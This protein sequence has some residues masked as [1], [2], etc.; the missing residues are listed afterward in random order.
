VPSHQQ[1]F[2]HMPP[3]APRYCRNRVLGQIAAYSA[4]AVALQGYVVSHLLLAQTITFYALACP[5]VFVLTSAEPATRARLP[6][7]LAL[8]LAAGVEGYAVFHGST[9]AAMVH[10]V[11]GPAALPDPADGAGSATTVAGGVAAVRHALLGF[12]AF[13]ATQLDAAATAINP[14]WDHTVSLHARPVMM[15]VFDPRHGRQ[16]SLAAAQWGVRYAL[17]AFVA[18]QLFRAVRA[19]QCEAAAQHDLMARVERQLVALQV[20]LDGAGVAG[21][22]NTQ[23]GSKTTAVQGSN[24]VGEWLLGRLRGL[25]DVFHHQSVSDRKPARPVG[26][27][28]L[29][30]TDGPLGSDDDDGD[31][32]DAAD[33]AQ[34]LAEV[35][36]PTRSLRRTRPPSQPVT[37]APD[38]EWL[39]TLDAS[40][41]VS[42]L[43][44]LRTHTW[45]A[46]IQ[47]QGHAGAR[48]SARAWGLTPL[49]Q[50]PSVRPYPIFAG[51]LSPTDHALGVGL[52]GGGEDNVESESD[53]DTDTSSDDDASQTTMDSITDGATGDSTFDSPGASWGEEFDDH[54]SGVGLKRG[55]H[56]ATQQ[57]GQRRDAAGVSGQG[58]DGGGDPVVPEGTGA[59][60]R[61]RLGG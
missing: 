40:H 34:L 27:F 15:A 29:C 41:G 20:R 30:L 17:L 19:A 14:G 9:V 7:F 53:A 10:D 1:R 32:V 28:P 46:L 35:A 5:A 38:D 55:R 2:S 12:L 52:S 42:A 56:Q 39:A 6:S 54:G 49:L 16:W 44:R 58:E 59:P 11:L 37:L 23:P 36:A 51:V 60:K 57:R 47:E 26:A 61:R 8:G 18:W 3:P 4:A 24:A 43:H 45:P 31:F 25:L 48:D 33:D 21:G 13:L 22:T 50:A